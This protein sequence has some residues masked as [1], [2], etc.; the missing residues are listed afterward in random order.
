[1]IQFCLVSNPSDALT[2]A[3]LNLKRGGSTRKI[4]KW[5]LS[6]LKS[7]QKQ[8][9]KCF[10]I[11]TCQPRH[12][13][14]PILSISEIHSTNFFDQILMSSHLVATTFLESMDNFSP[15]RRVPRHCA[16]SIHTYRSENKR[17][18]PLILSQEYIR[19]RLFITTHVSLSRLV[20][21]SCFTFVDIKC[22]CS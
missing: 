3:T 11:R 9:K 14:N 4:S 6:A 15:G 20:Q 19:Y 21:S 22:G 12:L 17:W 16:T 2:Q 8:N 10:T 13:I 5:L 18:F 7:S 1:M